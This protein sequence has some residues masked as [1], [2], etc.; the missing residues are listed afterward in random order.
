MKWICGQKQWQSNL[1]WNLCEA[2]DNWNGTVIVFIAYAIE[3]LDV[4]EWNFTEC[5]YT[6]GKFNV[7]FCWLN[8]F[9]VC[10][11]VR[12]STYAF[13]QQRDFCETINETDTSFGYV[14]V[15]LKDAILWPEH[16]YYRY[17]A[18]MRHAMWTGFIAIV[19]CKDFNIGQ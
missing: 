7:N 14:Y 8:R 6:N 17:K 3:L 11:F 12:Y 18:R 19:Y 10:V 1:K 4:R 13:V 9:C 5:F 2:I 15:I 16:I